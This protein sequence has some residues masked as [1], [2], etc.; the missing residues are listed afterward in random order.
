MIPENLPKG[1]RTQLEIIGAAHRLFLANGYH[2][3]SMRQIA[4]AAGIAVSGIYNHFNSKEEI[5]LA[6]LKQYH[7]YVRILPALASAQGDTVEAFLRNAAR[8]MVESVEESSGFLNLL[9][10]ELVEFNGQHISSLFE[11]IYPQVLEVVHRFT[12]GR[13]ELRPIPLPILLRAFIGLFFSYVMTEL[14]I[15]RQMPA[16]M[17]ENALDY[18]IDIFLHGVL[19]DGRLGQEGRQEAVS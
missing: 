7:P 2:G 10:I 15:R 9:F 1:E 6:V 19:I 17:Q 8:N 14:L 18:F 16:D 4:E 3:T 5:F 11:E 12:Q 13:D